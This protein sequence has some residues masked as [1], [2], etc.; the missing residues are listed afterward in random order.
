MASNQAAAARRQ[1]ERARQAKK[2][3]KMARREE[4]REQKK[5]EGTVASADP[6]SDPTIDWGD[7]VREVTLPDAE[8]SEAEGEEEAAG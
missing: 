3:E 5:A 1:R 4:R 8:T 2:K 6:A 7:A